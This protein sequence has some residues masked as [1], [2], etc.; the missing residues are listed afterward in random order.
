MAYIPPEMRRFYEDTV[1]D[2]TR[3]RIARGGRPRL[4][5]GTQPDDYLRQPWNDFF[6]DPARDY[7]HAV[8]P[9]A[10]PNGGA[11]MSTRDRIEMVDAARKIRARYDQMQAQR[12][13]ADMERKQAM[14][15][16]RQNQRA[17][18]A[19]GGGPPGPNSGVGG[20]VQGSRAGGYV[21]PPASAPSAMTRGESTAMRGAPSGAATGGN[22][23]G[24]LEG[25]TGVVGGSP[26]QT[27][28]YKA[29]MANGPK[30]QSRRRG[31][32]AS[33]RMMGYD[34][35][36]MPVEGSLEM[37]MMTVPAAKRNRD[38][39]IDDT[40]MQR[41]LAQGRGES[42]SD[43]D[44][45][46][47]AAAFGS[48]DPFAV[49]RNADFRRDAQGNVRR[50]QADAE[51]ELAN[52]MLDSENEAV[53]RAARASIASTKRDAVEA[54]AVQDAVLRSKTGQPSPWEQAEMDRQFGL[55]ERGV[56][57]EAE[58]I[59]NALA[60]ATGDRE[61]RERMHGA[62]LGFNREELRSR[63]EQAA[64]DRMSTAE[65]AALDRQL[66]SDLGFGELRSREGIEEAN[67][68]LQYDTAPMR[69]A[70]PVKPPP[71]LS[72]RDELVALEEERK[73]LLDMRSPEE[74][75]P[76]QRARHDEIVRRRYAIL[77]LGGGGD[78]PPDMAE[79]E[80]VRAAYPNETAGMSDEEI[81][82]R[83][84]R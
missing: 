54:A 35:P 75:P 30:A 11:S 10:G 6:Y 76:D 4:F 16:A 70:D 82:R 27:A 28:A 24:S 84:A 21:E 40:D 1:A 14:L 31:G 58:Q 23:G 67:R 26:M 38:T 52:A 25:A 56:D 12:A 9:G 46:S 13:Q 18:N 8:Y 7:E 79:V 73:A 81:M 74:L 60:I 32:F 34:A 59:A 65:Q 50:D 19:A 77:N 47:L 22:A 43:A 61:S 2:T 33:D 15:A 66:R 45:E 49:S 53:A 57:L 39:R 42:L 72:P 36:D 83:I 48:Y 29:G 51:Y 63:E 64:F 5:G 68:Q 37:A 20:A 3:D 62:G 69:W 44:A 80:E 17:V 78:A 71:T 41:F 55:K